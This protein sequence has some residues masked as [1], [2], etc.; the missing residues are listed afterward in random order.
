MADKSFSLGS[1]NIS[2][3]L[4][5]QA[6]KVSDPSAVVEK[7]VFGPDPPTTQNFTFTNL[8]NELY[9]FDVY[10][11]PDG[12]ILAE[13]FNTFEI[14]VATGSLLSEWKFYQVDRGVDADP[15]AGDTIITDSYLD[16]K[17]VVAIIQRGLGPL[18]PDDEWT[19]TST[20]IAL[21]GSLVFN[22]DDVYTV[23]INYKQ[24]GSSSTGNN[25]ALFSTEKTITGNTTLD[26]NYY[27]ALINLNGAGT[28]LVVTM[29][30]VASVPDGTMFYFGD[31][32]G[33][34]QFQTK[35]VPQT[36]EAILWMGALM[37]EIWVG[38][39]ETLWLKKSGTRYKVVLE[40]G[41]IQQVG[42]RFSGTYANHW[43]TL[44][45][46]N[47]LWGADDFPRLWWWI[48]NRLPGSSYLADDNLDLPGYIRPA[49][50]QGQF[51][52]SVTKRKFR[53]PDTQN[54]AEKG[55]KSFT[56]PGG[57]GTR[58]IDQP[59]GFQAPSLLSHFHVMHG[60]GPINGPAGNV[61]LNRTG[62]TMAGG[63]HRF[64]GG[65]TDNLG[66]SVA[67]DQTMQTGATGGTDNVVGNFGVIYCRCA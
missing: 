13:L 48:V 61:F 15:V 26:S 34:A 43:N 14:D 42:R 50:R 19:R 51:I 21:A 28:Q 22:A 59:G 40:H 9:F 44:V 8:D 52:V 45:E 64:S 11:S 31:L 4:I 1:I 32:E 63:P 41:N 55:L 25:P 17:N 58:I 54:L 7:Q 38:K 47:T 5:V 30:H 46:N 56:A 57:D 36:T 53:M 18:K 6:R 3:Y 10:E 39:G 60:E 23:V 20:G 62:A 2:D 29:D 37:S 35:I 49:N 33:G 16:G 67:P 66:G 27:N 24:A 65:G 12:V